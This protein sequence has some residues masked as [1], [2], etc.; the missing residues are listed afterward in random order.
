MSYIGASKRDSNIELKYEYIATHNQ[1]IFNAVHS[2][3]YID[4]YLNGLK[5]SETDFSESKNTITLNTPC[6]S[7][8]LVSINAKE[9]NGITQSE[10]ADAFFTVAPVL[11]GPTSGNK[12]TTIVITRDNHDSNAVYFTSVTAGTIVDNNDGTLNWTLPDVSV[13]TPCYINEYA[14]TKGFLKSDTTTLKVD[15]LYVPTTAPVLSGVS[16]GNEG[17]TVQIKIANYDVDAISYTITVTGGSYRRTDNV[18][19][20]TLPAVETDT[21]HTMGVLVTTGFGPSAMTNKTVQVLNVPIVADT[22]VQV[23]D[24]LAVEDTNDGFSHI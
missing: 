23:T 5:L 9:V 3:G 19:S 14:T 11:S 24:Y 20:W 21:N 8:D 4:V 18:I 16:S 6:T 10:F 17:S 13:D 2:I 7:G 15:A 1:T 22:A 12:L